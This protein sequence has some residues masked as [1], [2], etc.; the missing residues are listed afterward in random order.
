MS[1]E[2]KV[3]LVGDDPQQQ[4]A[5][6]QPSTAPAASS[7][8]PESTTTQPTQPAS[9]QPSVAPNVSSSSTPA[10]Q[11]GI[12]PPPI[13]GQET[14]LIDT[15]E[16]LIES[17][18]ELSTGKSP[19]SQTPQA[20]APQ[21][22]FERFSA[23][24]DKK[25]EEFGLANTAIGNLVSGASR[26]FSGLGTRATQFASSVFGAGAGQAAVAG[27]EAAAGAG[28]AGAATG[29]G[30]AAGAGATAAATAAGPLIAVALAAGLAA[31][32]V[33]KFMEAVDSVAKDLADLSPDIAIG[34][35]QSDM[36]ME[37]MRLDRAQRIGPDVANL[38]NAQ[39]RLFESMYEVQT[40]I[41]EL[42]FKASPLIETGI[43]FLDVL[44][45][46]IN[47]QI[48]TLAQIKA[49]MTPFDLSDDVQALKDFIK[50]NKDLAD[51]MKTLIE[52][53]TPQ[54]QGLDPILAEILTMNGNPG[55]PPP[56]PKIPR[57][58]GGGRGRG[59]RP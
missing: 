10:D 50:A 46:G 22:W 2:L 25:I 31:L 37:L 58:P 6:N 54:F 1:V 41:Y 17:L 24:V 57:G 8:Q 36:R 16:K 13:A 38:N 49:L 15:I 32:S 52:G 55:Q 3:T 33:K 26:S 59:A 5:F 40:K 18:E 30:A 47:V 7:T 39:N 23:N 42:I 29:A 34:Q 28:A 21:S 11:P 14:R 53:D 45:N 12:V 48:A 20:S 44:V 9:S 27:G 19:S 51:S 35:A 43:N 56:P 4:Q